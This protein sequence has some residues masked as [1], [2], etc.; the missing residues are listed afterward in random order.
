[1]TDRRPA[2]ALLACAVLAVSIPA[3]ADWKDDVRSKLGARPD[4]A[5]ARQILLDAWPSI[6]EDDRGSASLLRAYVSGRLA[7][8]ADEW[9]WLVSFF[10]TYGGRHALHLVLDDLSHQAVMGYLTQWSVRYPRVLDIAFAAA[11]DT[12]SASPPRELALG[13][14][15]ARDA[16]YKLGDDRGPILGG[17]FHRGWNILSFRTPSLEE[18]GTT[19]YTLDLKAGPLSVRKTIRLDIDL[20]EEA[21]ATPL[22]SDQ[23]PAAGADAASA[24]ANRGYTLSLY[25]DDELILSGTKFPARTA[26]YHINLPPL[27]PDGYKPWLPPDRQSSIVTNSGSILT[28]L[29]AIAGVIKDLLAKRKK[30]PSFLKIPKTKERSF[31]YLRFGPDGRVREV[32]VRLTLKY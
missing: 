2:A 32:R 15:M 12:R 11:P 30:E 18:A 20:A 23:H 16:L 17:A 5:A 28:A 27:F 25:L 31:S 19:V 14:D 29:G 6:A 13:V 9:T 10:E 22:P 21:P 3:R 26:D 4:Y 7:D 1:M 24:L 8:P